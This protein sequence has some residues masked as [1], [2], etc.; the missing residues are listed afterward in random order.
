VS[1]GAAELVGGGLDGLRGAVELARGGREVR[2]VEPALRAGAPFVTESFLT[3]FRFNLGQ[4]LV[5]R[6]DVPGFELLEP[7]PL[8]AVGG[9]TLGRAPVALEPGETGLATLAANGVGDPARR[10]TLLG[11]GL[12]LGIDPEAPGSGAALAGLAA[13][14]DDLVVVAGGNGLVGAVLC[15]EL[16]AAGGHLVEGAGP[17]APSEPFQGLGMCRLFVGLRHTRRNERAFV[18]AH[19]FED[20]QSL[21]SS[22]D[23]LR[24]GNATRALGFVVDN[25]HLDPRGALDER[26]GSLVWQGPLQAGAAIDRSAYTASVLEALGLDERDVVFTLLWLPEETGEPLG[27][28]PWPRTARSPALG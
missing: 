15:D 22:L 20:E 8:I 21:A 9:A 6:S 1:S 26:L 11:L 28:L 18:E 25:A 2:F 17:P 5:L 13:R 14:L 12:A 23:R 16:V 3:P 24:L 19:G 7:D 27:G 4:S 10:I